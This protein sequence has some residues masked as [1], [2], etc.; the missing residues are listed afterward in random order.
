MVT[1]TTETRPSE[2]QAIDRE[3]EKILAI[4]LNRPG[5]YAERR[6]MLERMADAV[7]TT[8]HPEIAAKL[9]D[10]H[11]NPNIV[12]RDERHRHIEADYHCHRPKLCP[13]DA[14]IEA[15]RRMAVYSDAI[16]EAAQSYRLQFLT[17]TRPNAPEGELREAGEGLWDDWRKLRRRKSMAPVVGA[18]VVQECTA[19]HDDRTWHPHLH[20]L[21][22]VKSK[23]DADFSWQ[24]VH[25]D[26]EELSGGIVTNFQSVTKKPMGQR[27]TSIEDTAEIL[28]GTVATRVNGAAVEIM[29][30]LSKFED[31]LKLDASMFGE[32]YE[33]YNTAGGLNRRMWSYGIWYGLRPEEK[34]DEPEDKEPDEPEDKDTPEL[35]RYDVEWEKVE[36]TTDAAVKASVILIRSNRS[37]SDPTA[38]MKAILS[39]T[40]RKA[41]SQRKNLAW[42]AWKYCED[43]RLDQPDAWAHVFLAWLTLVE[44]DL[45]GELLAW[46][47]RQPWSLAGRDLLNR[48]WIAQARAE[49]ENRKVG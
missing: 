44:L 18:I 19:N 8:Y 16:R 49:M 17:F 25:D 42:M 26:W 31:L 2:N 22:A 7:R 43:T 21:I 29:K 48:A 38:E 24:A 40:A 30:Y 41:S 12:F 6:T 45:T 32:W 39:T 9:D 23:Q 3:L 4:D 35:S 28:S 33:A 11:K 5:G 20:A 15:S 47:D 46:L 10:C 27:Q 13:F 14:R 1:E 34:E 36:N 37:T